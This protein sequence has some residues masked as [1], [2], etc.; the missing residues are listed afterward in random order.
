[1]QK[2]FITCAK[3]LKMGYSKKSKQSK[4][5]WLRSQNIQLGLAFI[6][7]WYIMTYD[8]LQLLNDLWNISSQLALNHDD[9]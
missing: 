3:V 2:C 9:L 5:V 6:H 7:D 4:L 8:L 1:M